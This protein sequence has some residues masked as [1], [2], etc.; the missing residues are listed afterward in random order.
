MTKMQKEPK[1]QR[2]RRK[3]KESNGMMFNVEARRDSV[4]AA[5][6]ATTLKMQCFKQ[7]II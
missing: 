5:S 6:E 1:A 4:V 7:K 3:P 2:T